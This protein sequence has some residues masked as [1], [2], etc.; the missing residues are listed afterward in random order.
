MR[1][2]WGLRLRQGRSLRV[3]EAGLRYSEAWLL[4]SIS[5]PRSKRLQLLF[6]PGTGVSVLPRRVHPLLPSPSIPF[7]SRCVPELP[8][9]PCF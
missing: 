5:A 3:L 7:P 6:V 9:S 4:L 1:P 8:S 2:G